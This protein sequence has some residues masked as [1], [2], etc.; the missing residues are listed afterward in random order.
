[1][2]LA[3][4][5]DQEL[6]R[7]TFEQLLAT[8]S[9]FERVREAEAEGFDRALWQTLVEVGAPGLRVPEAR[10]GTGGSLLDAVLLA[11]QVGRQLASAPII[12]AIVACAGLA[13]LDSDPA[14]TIVR[15]GLEGGRVVSFAPRA[16]DQGS[17]LVPGGAVATTVVGFDGQ[18]LAALERDAPP[19]REK[20]IG[21]GALARWSFA[22]GADPPR[23]VVLA[24]GDEARRHFERMREEWRLLTASALTGLGRH[25]IEIAARY[26]SERVQFDRPIGSF[27]AIAHPLAELATALEGAGMLIWRATEAVA[28]QAPDAATL[29]ALAFAW[30][31]EHTPRATRQALHTHGGYGLSDE[32]DIQLFHRRA[33]AWA[34]MAGDPRVAYVDAADRRWRGHAPALPDA[35]EVQLDFGLGERATRFGEEARRFFEANPTPPELLVHQHDFDGHDPAFQRKM[36]E[37]G[38]LYASWPEKYGGRGLDVYEVAAFNDEIRAAGR[39]T[40]AIGTTSMVGQTLSEFASEELKQEVLPRIIRGEAICSLGYTEPGS[41]SDVAAAVTRAERDGDHWVINGQKMFTSGA[42]IGQYVFLLTRTNAEARKHRGLTMFLVPLDTDGIEIQPIHTLSDERT[43]ATYYNDVRVSDRYRVG[44]ID[45]GWTVLGHALHIEHGGS[46]GT[47]K[48]SVFRSLTDATAQW[49]RTHERDGSPAIDDPHFRDVLARADAVAEI[50]VALTLR[51]L[52]IVANDLPDNGAGA[53]ITTFQKVAMPEIAARLMD[54]T[55]PESV[56]KRGS[57]GAVAEGELEFGY[58]LASA[59][60]IYGGTA[61]IVK[62]I[63]AQSALGLP[64]SRS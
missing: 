31:A 39:T 63:V 9:S 55:A 54:L 28:R 41:G 16:F 27:Q 56:L 58:R 51:N 45:G 35:G 29:C 53:M 57:T 8:E 22:D 43:N 48:V 32:Y 25:A 47:G 50:N 11:E 26:A 46:E 13:T 37:A 60:A 49:G 6:L 30:A 38:L 36:A 1:M 5:S 21:S 62:S 24:E 64:R 61:E 7:E 33:K 3:L 10:G 17:A 34:L 20:D 15:E 18:T 12:E 42:N 19:P 2:N 40:H 23:R 52:W 44:P 4:T 14:R 59:N